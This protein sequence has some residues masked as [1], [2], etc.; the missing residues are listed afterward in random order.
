MTRHMGSHGFPN[1]AV[2]FV[3]LADRS[4][5]RPL[6]CYD[7]MMATIHWLPLGSSVLDPQRRA[8]GSLS[9]M[10]N[11]HYRLRSDTWF[12]WYTHI[13]GSQAIR[14]ICVPNIG[15]KSCL[16]LDQD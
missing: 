4:L 14:M 1:S 13:W 5:E 2:A 12:A 3:W 9:Y 11:V 15:M 7:N 8:P 6:I 10:P 16:L